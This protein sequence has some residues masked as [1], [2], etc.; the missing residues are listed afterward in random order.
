MFQDDP[1][2]PSVLYSDGI[3]GSSLPET[4]ILA[5]AET[6][7]ISSKTSSDVTVTDMTGNVIEFTGTTI[8]LQDLEWP[9]VWLKIASFM[10]QPQN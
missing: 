6:T 2:N 9:V 1:P 7:V 10:V 5:S 4:S 3:E 8:N